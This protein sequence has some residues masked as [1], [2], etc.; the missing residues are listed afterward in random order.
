[1][2]VSSVTTSNTSAINAFLAQIKAEQA[3]STPAAAKATSLKDLGTQIVQSL[4]DSFQNSQSNPLASLEGANPLADLLGANAGSGTDPLGDLLGLGSQ[5]QPASA[6]AVADL[7]AQLAKTAPGPDG[8]SARA[9]I[10]KAFA[11]GQGSTGA[12]LSGS[13]LAAALAKTTPGA[14]GDQARAA[15][16]ATL[17]AGQSSAATQ[18]ITSLF[19][20]LG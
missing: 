4:E 16:V 11:S 2:A 9:A 15:L 19:N 10:V 5:S 13:D 18:G 8:D 6:K 14:D 7:A 3:S 17:T 1:M 20:Y 12:T